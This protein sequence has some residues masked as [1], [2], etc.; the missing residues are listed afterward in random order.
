MSK[1]FITKLQPQV[2]FLLFGPVGSLLLADA[3]RRVV[4]G[5]LKVHARGIFGALFGGNF[6]EHALDAAVDFGH[7]AGVGFGYLLLT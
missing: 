1:Y 4:L 5:F 6:V 2:V 7:K 3:R